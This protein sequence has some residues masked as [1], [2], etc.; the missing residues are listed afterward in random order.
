MTSISTLNFI[1]K[2]Q[3][4]KKTASLQHTINRIK[5]NIH[6]TELQLSDVNMNKNNDSPSTTALINRIEAIGEARS[7][8]R[9]LLRNQDL[10]GDLSKH[11]EY[12]DSNHIEESEKLHD[13]R[14]RIGNIEDKITEILD[15]IEPEVY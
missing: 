9:Q 1:A 14:M 8:L 5:L 4:Q 2:K 13:L 3:Q 10:F 15:V 12:F 7:L 11:N 6:T